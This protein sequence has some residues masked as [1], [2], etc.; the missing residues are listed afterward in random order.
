MKSFRIIFP[1]FITAA[2]LVSMNISMSLN[3]ADESQQAAFER[4]Q[5]LLAMD[6]SSIL[7]SSIKDAETGLR[8]YLLTQD[9]SYLEPYWTAEDNIKLQLKMLKKLMQHDDHKKDLY[10]L[11]PIIYALMASL[12]TS[13]EFISNEQSIDAY[14]KLQTGSDKKLMENI[15]HLIGLFKINETV[16]LDQLDKTF[17][18]S[19][20]R[21]SIISTLSSAMITLMAIIASLFIYHASRQQ[22]LLHKKTNK[23][24]QQSNYD[25]TNEVEMRHKAEIELRIVASTFELKNGILVTDADG[26]IL[27]VNS[28]FT[29]T[30]GYSPQDAIGKTPYILSSKKHDKAFYANMWHQVTHTGVWEGD[31]W[32]RRKDGTVHPEYL[33]ITAI[34]N[35]DGLVVNYVASLID[36]SHRL[37]AEDEI[38]QLAFYD[39]LTQL[40][41]RRLLLKRLTQA[42]AKGISSGKQGALFFIDLDNFKSINDTLGHDIGDVLLQQVAKRLT[43]CVR[44]NDTVARLGGDEFVVML[45][46]V[47]ES[48]TKTAA[49]HAETKG[50]QILNSL[51]QAYVLGNKNYSRH[52]SPSIGITLFGNHEQSI[53]EILKQADIAMYK[54]KEDGRNMLRFFDPK[55]QTIVVANASLEIDLREALHKNQLVLFYQ[56]QTTNTKIIGAEALIRWHHPKR[57]MV[58]PMEFIALAEETG[59][60]I[61]IGNWVLRTSCEQLKKWALNPL[62]QHLSLSINVSARQFHQPDFIEQVQSIIDDSGLNNLDKL[63]FELTES[64]ILDDVDDVILK[65]NQLKGMGILFSMDDFGTG[66]SSLSYLTRLPLDQIKIDKSFVEYIG[67]KHLDNIMVQSIISLAKELN[68]DIIAEGV[69]TENQRLFLERNGCFSCQGYLFSKPLPLREFEL[70]IT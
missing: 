34:K 56:M 9:N 45:M 48:S 27:R 7:L 67:K 21:V 68:L 30:T 29:Q 1:L 16:K 44:K 31:T 23:K 54:A 18:Y 42:L 36:I 55:M 62:T 5:S 46:D 20:R 35:N 65:M 40:P 37:A 66:Y 3:A 49:Q 43:E 25:L 11:E 63:K 22:L 19:L 13:V 51:N 69:E 17:N 24:L 57:G 38:K 12:H 70:L 50:Q 52:V 26:V 10:E 53:E 41:N 64:V 47:T 33:T 2:I 8:G 4:K 60:I 32:N 28:A 59:L 14:A 6:M 15:R 58:M 61:P 39:H